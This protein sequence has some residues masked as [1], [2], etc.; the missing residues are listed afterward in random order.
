MTIKHIITA[1]TL[2]AML[3]S[4]HVAAAQSQSLSVTQCREMALAHSETI[5]RGQ[6]A[7]SRAELD[8]Q[9]AGN[10]MLPQ[11]DGS[12]MGVVAK[13]N[14]IMGYTLQMRGVYLAGLTLTQPIYV[15][16]KIVTGKKLAQIGK[17]CAELNAQRDRAQV[18]A[19]VDNAYYS[20]LA[21]RSKLDVLAA[22]RTQLEA[23]HSTVETSV[24]AQMATENDL[25]RIDAKLS[26]I[27]Y[28]QQK[29]T[30]GEQLCRMVLCNAIGLDLGTAVTLADTVL[31]STLPSLLDRDI[32]QRPE[33]QLLN[34][35]IEARELQ[36]KMERAE[37]LPTVALQLGYSYYGNIKMKGSVLAEDGNYYPFSKEYHGDV[38]MAMLSVQIPLWHWGTE[39][40]KMKQAQLDVEDARLDLEENSRLM[41]IE[42]EQAARNVQDSFTMIETA[43][44]GLEQAQENLRVMRLKHEHAMATL[45]DVL[46]AH[47][48]WQQAQSNLIEART[49]H[50]INLTEYQRV[51][52]RLL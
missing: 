21:V 1:F 35:Q 4:T 7:I 2:A 52:G 24:K 12:L 40:K 20:L 19:D 48:Q 39:R 38:P 31:P 46:D 27:L 23:L 37:M 6:N 47:A 15:G 26:E 11:L 45:T 32:S 28:Q 8:R 50:L 10:A 33:V 36:V 42:A 44:R 16:G 30:N 9:I 22:Y 14:D 41:R 43:K 49:Q 29:A 3:C 18:I 25:L 34:K 5:K 13:D 51:T 17:D